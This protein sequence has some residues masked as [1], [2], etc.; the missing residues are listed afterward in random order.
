MYLAIS[1]RPDILHSVCKLAQ[2]EKPVK[3]ILRYLRS[4]KHLRIQYTK[5]TKPLKGFVD[6]DWG[7]YQEDR[8][9]HIGFTSFLAGCSFSWESK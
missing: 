2:Y 6:A 9:H 4:T 1:T 3:H 8:R 7:S 5:I